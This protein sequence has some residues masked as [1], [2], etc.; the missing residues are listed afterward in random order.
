MGF[1]AGIHNPELICEIEHEMNQNMILYSVDGYAYYASLQRVLENR[2]AVLG[3]ASDQ[4]AIIVR[5]PDQTWA[6][7]GNSSILE[8]FTLLDLWTVVAK[9]G[10]LDEM[11]TGFIWLPSDGVT[12]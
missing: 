10:G 7:Q 12:P 11:P 9:T 4:N 1:F 3:P 8:S 6:P 5:H 2:I